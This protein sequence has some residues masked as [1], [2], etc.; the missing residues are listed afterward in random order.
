MPEALEPRPLE[1][2]RAQREAAARNGAK[3]VGAARRLLRSRDADALDMRDVA[4]AAGV[5]VGTVYRRFGDKAGL[6]AA[7]VGD[8][9]RDLQDALL[10]GPPP[11]GP[12]APASERLTAFLEALA[13]LTERNIGALLVTDTT[14]PGRLHIGAYG[15]WRLHV[16]ALLSELR[17]RLAP[18]DAGW[19]ADVLLAPLDPRLYAW[20]RRQQGLSRRRLV[21]NLLV[22]ARDL[23]G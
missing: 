15:A 16:A 11:L 14:P 17:P 12:G 13:A 23:T 4:K 10:H 20:Q 3:I 22:L 6:L 9:E 8:D 2:W 5:G 19:T 21:A 18:A 7:I 1:G